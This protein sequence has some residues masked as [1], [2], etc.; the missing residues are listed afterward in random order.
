MNLANHIIVFLVC[1]WLI[2]F[3]VLPWGVKNHHEEQSEDELEP[4]IE[5]AAPVRANIGKK[6]LI[7]T[8]ITIVVW[9]SIFAA[10]EFE[11]FSIR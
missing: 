5:K 7:T 1:W 2:L 11:L 6:M 3:M 9:L 4:G 8:G 10:I